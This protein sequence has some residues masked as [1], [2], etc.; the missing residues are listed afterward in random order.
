MTITATELFIEAK[1]REDILLV[2]NDEHQLNPVFEP[3]EPVPP[4]T[5]FIWNEG[6]ND[7]FVEIGTALDE[8]TIERLVSKLTCDPT[9]NE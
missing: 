5:A 7:W 6:A 2:S 4:F 1:E 8:P 9:E 3:G